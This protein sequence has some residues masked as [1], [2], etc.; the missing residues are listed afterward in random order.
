MKLNLRVR[1]K[2]KAFVLTFLVTVIGFI[3]QVLGMFEFVPKISQDNLIQFVSIFVNL[4]AGLGILV[5]PT[6]KGLSDSERVLN[7]K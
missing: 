3:Y 4:L 5:D 1:L 2:N 7:K 6:T